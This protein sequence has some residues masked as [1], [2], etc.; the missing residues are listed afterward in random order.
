MLFS[1]L[2]PKANRLLLLLPSS[3][4]GLILV[5]LLSGAYTDYEPLNSSIHYVK[6]EEFTGE[7]FIISNIPY[8][9]EKNKVASKAN[10]ILNEK[11]EIDDIFI[12]QEGS[13]DAPVDIIKGS[14]KSL[15]QSNTQWQ[16]T[17]Y[18][19]IKFD[20]EILHMTQQSLVHCKYLPIIITTS[21][22]S[23]LFRRPLNN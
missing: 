20:F 23:E 19:L 3:L 18:W 2:K 6:T 1:F 16:S 4:L 21:L 8:F 15:N 11:N 12:S 7:W 13:F 22:N 9:A 14:V 5:I 17:F 10:Y